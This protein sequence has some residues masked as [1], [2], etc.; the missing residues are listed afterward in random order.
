[1]GESKVDK[2]P[3]IVVSICAVVLLVLV[4]LSN[5]VGYQSV[6]STMV[7]DSP[8]FRIRTQ[9]IIHQ[10]GNMKTSQ[11][12]EEGK[13]FENDTTPPVTTIYFVPPEPNGLNNWYVSNIKI[14][15]EAT[16]DISGVD[17]IKY[18][19][20]DNDWMLYTSPLIITSDDY[21]RIT[22]YA[23][24]NAGNVEQPSEV[25][26][27]KL[28]QTKPDIAMNYTWYGN[29]FQGIDFIFTVTATD[30]MSG[31]DYV[32]FWYNEVKQKTVTGAGPDYVW[33]VSYPFPSFSPIIKGIAFDKAG[34]D[35]FRSIENPSNYE[36][37]H[38]Q[39]RT[40]VK[41]VMQ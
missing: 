13:G 24:D 18:L 22:Y 1:M 35:D 12:P 31:M 4:S 5:V 25:V 6:K 10:Q 3:L 19:L 38:S 21:H 16:D 8:L 32:E 7:N 40:V 26:R 30:A 29:L 41:Q 14:T 11:Y 28:D 20:D 36:N 2:K 37:H 17:F 9:R 34:N 15:L 23:V 27:F 33:E 39:R